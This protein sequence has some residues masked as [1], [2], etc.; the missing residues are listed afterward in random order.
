VTER[1]SSHGQ[2]GEWNRYSDGP[3]DQQY[4]GQGAP[5]QQYYAG[6]AD[7]GF[8]GSEA[9][10]TRRSATRQAAGQRGF[11]AA[12]FDFGFTSFITTKIIKVLYALVV[13]MVMLA[14][15]L[16]TV[17]AFRASPAFGLLALVIGDPLY[18]IISLA[19]W[20][21]WSEGAIAFF[22]IAEDIRALRERTDIH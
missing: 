20:R 3:A 4:S 15:L 8:G 1:S 19:L 10:P 5:G 17:F 13:I 9:A 16:F 12:L 11:I 7:T 22:R 18:I 14:A 21:V 2:P 6:T